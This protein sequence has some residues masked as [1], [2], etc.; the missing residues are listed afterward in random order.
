MTTTA[1]TPIPAKP[2][3]PDDALK[4]AHCDAEKAYGDLTPY[5][6]AI[7]LEPDGW[8]IDYE[9]K[10]AGIQGGGPHYVIDT[11]SGAILH[12]RYEQ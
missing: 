8:H 7:T 12:K 6:I 5:R 10:Q 9:F 4:V 3:S 11:N 1:S 2:I